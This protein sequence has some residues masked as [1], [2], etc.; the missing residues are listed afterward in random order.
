M[1]DHKSEKLVTGFIMKM[2]N[3]KKEDTLKTI[4]NVNELGFF[5]DQ[6]KKLIKK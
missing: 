3:K 6:I 5:I 4:K 1:V 2:G